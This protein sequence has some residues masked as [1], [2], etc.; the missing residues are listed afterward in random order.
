MK[1]N[2]FNP[3]PEIRV[4]CETWRMTELTFESETSY[5]DPFADVTA[6][7]VL[8][9]AGG[10]YLIPCF[11]DG[12]NI[13][14]VRF[15]CPAAGV[16]R[17]RTV[18]SDRENAALHGRTG[19]AVCAPYEGPLDVYR[20]GFV[21]TRYKKRYFTY[22]DGTPF[23]YLGDTHWSL[24]EETAQMV[25]TVGE[26]RIAQGFTVWQSEPIGAQFD[27]AKGVTEADIA[28]LRDYDEK[29]RII[30][31]L[32][33][34]H[35]NAQF[36]FP[37][38]M[39]ACIAAHGGYSDQLISGVAGGK[40]SRMPGLSAQAQGYLGRLARY[41]VARYGAFPVLWTL[42]QEVDDD[43]YWTETS[44]QRWNAVNNPY[45]IV[46]ELMARYD[47]Y[48]HPLTAHQENAALVGAYGSGA[49]VREKRRVYNNTQP[50]A[51]RDVPA[52]TF[53]AVQWSPPLNGPGDRKTE[54]DFRHN[55]QGKPVINYEGR[56][57]YLWTKNFGSRMQGWASYL[58]GMFGYGWG[59]QDTWSYLNA[60]D[61]DKDT[62][63]GVDTVT[64]AEK[65]AADWRGAMEYP[66]SYQ[67]GY[68]RR[69]FEQIPWH[70]LIP[71]FDNPSYFRPSPK[72][73]AYLAGN[74]DNTEIVIYFYSF[75]DQTV[76][77]RPN[78]TP[79][80]GV[81]TGTLGRLVPNGT[82]QYRWFD[83]IAGEYIGDG[84]FTA[85]PD[86]TRRLGPKPRTTDLVLLIRKTA[87][88]AP[89]SQTYPND[90][91]GYGV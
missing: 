66:S 42:G 50:S 53:Y 51:F 33:F 7:L 77:E 46:A 65:T 22:A 89:V 55:G 91:G 43:F 10:E 82:Y 90:K 24:G 41:W 71:R 11:W 5:A 61:E 17:F 60:Y 86:G 13:W 18:C 2:D 20:H 74:R 58:S 59:G 76:A 75:T 27:L 57:C 28:G 83:P 78:S 56:Y 26:K 64:S 3:L 19:E 21:T 9:G 63:D 85:S 31:D 87:Q 34:T 88:D 45:K 12:G 14:R 8:S 23:F 32:G 25:R 1:R 81:G 44:A 35:A 84:L 69:F 39:D 67:A 29:F 73:Y 68:M 79:E 49:G 52:H 37:S 40:E 54:R 47:P 38:R 62:D 70:A 80:G 16:W 30:A 72:V 48:G 4:S 15:A 36:F 6:D